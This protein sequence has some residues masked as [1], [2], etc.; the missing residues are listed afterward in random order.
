MLKLN[1]DKNAF[2]FFVIFFFTFLNHLFP[3]IYE[4]QCHQSK[5]NMYWHCIIKTSHFN[6]ARCISCEVCLQED[7]DTV[8]DTVDHVCV[9]G[10]EEI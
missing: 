8:V 3:H 9:S 7:F 2:S 10:A 6:I 4:F 5:Q 1:V